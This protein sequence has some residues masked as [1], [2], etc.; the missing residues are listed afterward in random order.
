MPLPVLVAQRRRQDTDPT[1]QERED[2]GVAERAADPGQPLG[3]LAG[4]EP[5]VRPGKLLL[6]LDRVPGW[7]GVLDLRPTGDNLGLQIMHD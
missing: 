4:N 3:V 2:V 5:V 7:R 1:L 6:L